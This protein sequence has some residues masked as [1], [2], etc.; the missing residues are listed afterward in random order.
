MLS[1]IF[2]ELR[3][4][5]HLSFLLEWNML[6]LDFWFNIHYLFL[7]NLP[8]LDSSGLFFSIFYCSFF[9]WTSQ[10]QY[11]MSVKHGTISYVRYKFHSDQSYQIFTRTSTWNIL[12]KV[13]FDI[14]Q[15]LKTTYI[16]FEIIWF[17]ILFGLPTFPWY[18]L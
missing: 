13:V 9:L 3:F 15:F 16:T 18:K 11:N 5:N 17:Y 14:V 6:N 1:V 12:L 10:S 8:N 2:N 4:I 7:S